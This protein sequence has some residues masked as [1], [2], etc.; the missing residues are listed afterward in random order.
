[1]SIPVALLIFAS[2]YK[3]DYI[4]IKDSSIEVFNSFKSRELKIEDVKY[5]EPVAGNT[6]VIKLKNKQK[7]NLSKFRVARKDQEQFQKQMKA[8]Q[9]HFKNAN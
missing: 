3:E 7:I 1:M 4:I 6:W 8:L 2:F 5:V 9:K